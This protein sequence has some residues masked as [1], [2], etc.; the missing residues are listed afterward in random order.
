MWR[1]AGVL[2]TVRPAFKRRLNAVRVK[3]HP[4]ALKLKKYQ[5]LSQSK[6]LVLCPFV[7][8]SLGLFMTMLCC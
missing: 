8:G 7:C 3:N 4:Q 1:L 2:L 6:D 5:A